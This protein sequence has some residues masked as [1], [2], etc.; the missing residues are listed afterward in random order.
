VGGG[1]TT[2]Q[3]VNFTLNPGLTAASNYAVTVSGAG[4]TSL[5]IFVTITQAEIN[6]Q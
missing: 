1:L 2:N 5:P 4:I 6:K 3:T